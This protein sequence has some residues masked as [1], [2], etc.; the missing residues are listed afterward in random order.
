MIKAKYIA[1]ITDKPWWLA[2]GIPRDACIA[3]YQPVGASD[4]AASKVNLANPGTYDATEG[5]APTWDNVNGWK[6][7]ISYQYLKTGIMATNGYSLIVRFSDV[8]PSDRPYIMGG[9]TGYGKGIGI[10]V[11][12]TG[13]SRAFSYGSLSY[14]AGNYTSGVLA[15]TQKSTNST[16]AQEWYNGSLVVDNQAIDIAKF[17]GEI[18]LLANSGDWTGSLGYIQAAAIYNISITNYVPELT[19][20]MNAL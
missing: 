18:Y 8:T 20:A 5:T 17:G 4:Y 1:A 13:N 9:G 6:Q 7:T 2:G 19:A 12:R 15:A 16:V 11:A 14:P 10:G 3:A